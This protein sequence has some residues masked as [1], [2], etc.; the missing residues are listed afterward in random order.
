MVS[1]VPAELLGSL[2][3]EE[4]KEQ[5]D[6]ALFS[7]GAT[8]GALAFVP[9]PQGGS[10]PRSGCLLYPGGPGLQRLSILP[11]RRGAQFS[12]FCLLWFLTRAP[13]TSTGWRCRTAVGVPP[14]WTPAAASRSASS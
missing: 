2:L 11:T 13:Q 6:R 14:V 7:E 10:E 1:A 3:H 5:R 4:L 8:G 9:F 12:S